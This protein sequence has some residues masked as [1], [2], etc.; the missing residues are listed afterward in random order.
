MQKLGSL[1]YDQ[2][3]FDDADQL[4]REHGDVGVRAPAKPVAE[5]YGVECRLKIGVGL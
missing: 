1:L 4:W 2:E 3:V 5:A